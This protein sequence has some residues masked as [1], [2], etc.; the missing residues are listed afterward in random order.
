MTLSV[1][2]FADFVANWTFRIWVDI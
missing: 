1:I 2:K